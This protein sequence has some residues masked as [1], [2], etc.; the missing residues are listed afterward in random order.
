MRIYLAMCSLSLL[1]GVALGQIN[2][3]YTAASQFMDKCDRSS[4]VVFQDDEA[5]V[6]RH[7][8]CFELEQPTREETPPQ[9]PH[10]PPP[11]I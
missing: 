8:H 6:R 3:K 7:F 4:V 5:D 11:M 10:V 9:L 1:T 2:G